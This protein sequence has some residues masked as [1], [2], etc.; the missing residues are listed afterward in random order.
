MKGELIMQDFFKAVGYA[1]ICSLSFAAGFVG[2]NWLL[3]KFD[4]K[5]FEVIR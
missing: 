5:Y 3:K 2:A 1:T 4:K